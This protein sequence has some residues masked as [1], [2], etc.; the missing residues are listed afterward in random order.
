MQRDYKDKTMGKNK[1]REVYV[2][3]T[4]A[5]HQGDKLRAL[6]DTLENLTINL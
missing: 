3:D 4:Q 6:S 5:G 2:A 1:T